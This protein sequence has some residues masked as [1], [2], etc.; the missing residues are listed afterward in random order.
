MKTREHRGTVKVDRTEE[1]IRHEAYRLW[2]QEGCP[3]GR[4]LEHWLTAKEIVHHRRH[5]ATD[6][7][8]VRDEEV[9]LV[10]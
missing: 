8:K 1:Q 2:Q 3:E 10:E 9:L 6:E 7:R 4:E 5:E